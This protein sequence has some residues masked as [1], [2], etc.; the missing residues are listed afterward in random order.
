MAGVDSISH[1][2]DKR[3]THDRRGDIQFLKA[4]NGPERLIILPVELLREVKECL[5]F[6]KKFGLLTRRV[7]NVPF[8]I[9]ADSVRANDLP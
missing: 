4:F 8:L 2:K 6:F 3:V 1:H 7:W 9:E 5:T